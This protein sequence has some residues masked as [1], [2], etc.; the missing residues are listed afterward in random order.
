MIV[1]PS[2]RVGQASFDCQDPSQRQRVVEINEDVLRTMADSVR[3]LASEKV[4]H[5][6]SQWTTTTT[7]D[8]AP[9]TLRVWLAEK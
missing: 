5:R 4:C 1:Y 9:Q 2:R 6:F 8:R 7:A 3:W